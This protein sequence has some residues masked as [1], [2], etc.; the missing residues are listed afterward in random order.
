MLRREEVQHNP[1]SID[2][3]SYLRRIGKDFKVHFP[4]LLN[5]LPSYG[6]ILQVLNTRHV[7]KDNSDALYPKINLIACFFTT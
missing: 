5:G 3:N 2:T 6:Y 4:L 1:S 7:F